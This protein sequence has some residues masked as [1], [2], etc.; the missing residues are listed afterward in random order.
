MYGSKIK[1]IFGAL[2]IPTLNQNI[3][4]YLK[5]IIEVLNKYQN[6]KYMTTSKANRKIA[7]NHFFW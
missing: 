6:N 2:L 5:A 3:D 1:K 7:E 4:N